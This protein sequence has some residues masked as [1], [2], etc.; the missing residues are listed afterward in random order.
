MAKTILVLTTHDLAHSKLALGLSHKTVSP[1][2][3]IVIFNVS[4]LLL[5]FVFHIGKSEPGTAQAKAMKI[6][7]NDFSVKSKTLK[8]ESLFGSRNYREHK[9]QLR[10]VYPSLILH[11][12]CFMLL[13]K[14]SLFPN[15][16][17]H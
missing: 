7:C 3:T 5:F 13:C 4:L 15:K 11:C 8:I 16:E 17:N 10:W 9:Q 6:V 2:E 1:L 14:V 12:I